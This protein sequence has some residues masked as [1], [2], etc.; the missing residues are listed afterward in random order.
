MEFNSFA[1]VVSDKELSHPSGSLPSFDENM[2]D[3]VT[4]LNKIHPLGSW[5]PKELRASVDRIEKTQHPIGLGV[6]ETSNFTIRHQDS[7]G[8]GGRMIQKVGSSWSLAYLG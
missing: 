3:L 8:T 1:V 4:I 5:E 6:V 2:T 7:L